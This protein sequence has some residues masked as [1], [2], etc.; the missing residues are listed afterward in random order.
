MACINNIIT[1]GLCDGEPVALSGFRLVDAPEITVR[2]L[3]DIAS[4]TYQ[5]AIKLAQAKINLAYIQVKN[6]LLGAMQSNNVIPNI[7][8]QSYNTCT[9]NPSKTI[10]AANQERGITL[11]KSPKYRGKL[12]HTKITQIQV[13]PLSSG[14]TNI[15]IYDGGIKSTFP[16]T[17]VADQINTFEIEYTITSA[18]ARILINDTDFSM[19]SAMGIC[20]IGCGGKQPNECGFAMGWNGVTDVNK[21]EGYGINVIF[22]CECD[23][24]QI[25]CDLA[26]SYIGEIIWLKARYN[27]ADERLHS[28][29]FS[30]LVI[31][32]KE[33]AQ[34][35]KSDINN[36]YVGKWNEL[37]AGF[38][39]ILKSYRGDE[40]CLLCRS[41]RWFVNV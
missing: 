10:I 16:V 18:F 22:K 6:D 23:Y 1:S 5:T 40:E 37:M 25:L 4:E 3:N 27:I 13:Y 31:Y 41:S 14:T 9:F 30:P 33:E 20:G 12:R 36:Q 2:N 34:Q 21:G 17:L 35:I 7:V 26:K 19:A 8:N 38:Y 28:D 11:H 39:N 29:R 24:D 15:F 32:G